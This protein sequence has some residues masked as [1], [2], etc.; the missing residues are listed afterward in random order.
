M[1]LIAKNTKP[2]IRDKHIN[3]RL[4][5]IKVLLLKI[6]GNILANNFE[7][8]GWNMINDKP[9]TINGFFIVLII[10]FILLSFF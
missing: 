1:V 10:V 6:F 4:D 8:Y 2:K 9:I 7:V 5:A 3:L